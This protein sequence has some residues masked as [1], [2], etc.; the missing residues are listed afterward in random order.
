[1]SK[2]NNKDGSY[3]EV[4]SLTKISD[5][6]LRAALEAGLNESEIS[7]V[8]SQTEKYGCEVVMNMICK[9]VSG[10]IDINTLSADNWRIFYERYCRY[11]EQMALSFPENTNDI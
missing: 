10:D 7:Y 8:L 2:K 11:L 1:M 3:I 5:E 4:P 9:D 6:F